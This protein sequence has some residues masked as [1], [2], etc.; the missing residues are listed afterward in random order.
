[1]LIAKSINEFVET[2]YKSPQT[3]RSYGVGLKRFDE[4]MNQKFM[5]PAQMNDLYE[6]M[7]V[8]FEKW[9][10]K[11]FVKANSTRTYVAAVLKWLNNA[12]LRQTLPKHISL[13]RTRALYKDSAKRSSYHSRD[14]QEFGDLPKVV[15]HLNKIP[16]RDE[17]EIKWRTK[18]LSALRNRAFMWFIYVTGARQGTARSL[19]IRQVCE[20]NGEIRNVIKAKGKGDK[21]GI[22]VVDNADARRA[23]LEYLNARQEIRPDKSEFVFISHDHDYG[24]PISGT[25][26]WRV[27]HQASKELGFDFSPHDARHHWAIEAIN[28]GMPMEIVQKGLWHASPTTTMQVYANINN[29]TLVNWIKRVPMPDAK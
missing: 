9:L 22:L 4:F 20:A 19:K 21:E 24:E 12:L 28:R 14:P 8:D 6:G 5:R 3:Q 17:T 2:L 10:D 18:Y 23:L 7:L 29:D 25:T 11:N 26:A 1:M 13:E 27:V 16:E 15:A